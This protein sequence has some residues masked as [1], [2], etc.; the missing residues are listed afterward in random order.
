MLRHKFMKKCEVV[1]VKLHTFLNKELH[2]GEWSAS[3]SDRFTSNTSLDKNVRNTLALKMVAV[4]SSET[5]APK[6]ARRYKQKTTSDTRR[7]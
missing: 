4:C 3:R 5:F 2:R 6:S 7:S 1:E